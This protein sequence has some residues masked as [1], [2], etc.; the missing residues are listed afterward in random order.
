MEIRRKLNKE[1]ETMSPEIKPYREAFFGNISGVLLRD[2]YH[3]DPHVCFQ[4]IHEDDGHWFL[5]TRG[6]STS[7]FEDYIGVLEAAKKWCEENCDPDIIDGQQYGWRFK[8]N[9]VSS[10]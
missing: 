5:S 2:R 9:A 3:G 8:R 1:H 4:I 10:L 7:W 6:A